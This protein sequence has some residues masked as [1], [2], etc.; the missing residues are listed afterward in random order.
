MTPTGGC[1]ASVRYGT[2]SDVLQVGERRCGDGA[3]M[4]IARAV[5]VPREVLEHRQQ[6][7]LTQPAR[8]GACIVG[9]HG[10]VGA[11]GP[12]T[13][14]G[15]IRSVGDVD[16]RR[17]VHREAS[18]AHRL[19]TLQGDLVH[20]LGR[21]GL[22]QHPRRRLGADHRGQPRHPATLLVDAHGEGQRGRRIG[23]VGQRSVGH[24]RQVGPAADHDAAD[25]VSF[26]DGPG[27][28][29][30][31]DTDHQQ[32]GEFVAGRDVRE[33]RGPLTACGR[34]DHRGRLRCRRARYRGRCCRLIRGGRARGDEC[35][36][37]HDGTQG[38]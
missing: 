33:Q 1:A 28:G 8:I 23:D 17:E 26:D 32:L 36:Q 22:R 7:R 34:R 31:G 29:G 24:H 3:G 11:E 6:A 5:P 16:H 13:D 19:T 30:V 10:R 37:R 15:V 38:A 9:D 25:M 21:I 12:V 20:L 4:R 35:G 27:V 18:T 14:H 2:R